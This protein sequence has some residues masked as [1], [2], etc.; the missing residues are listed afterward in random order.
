[1]NCTVAF[2]PVRKTIQIKASQERTFEI[3]AAGRWWP[4]QHTLLGAPRQ[5]LV[6]EPKAGGRWFERGTDGSECNWGKVLVWAPPERLVL[7]WEIN[8]H[9]QYDPS[10]TSEVEINFI[11]EG[12]QTTRVELEH[13]YFERFGDTADALRKGVD[14]PEG[15]TGV[16]RALAQAA[17]HS[18]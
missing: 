18:A 8:G 7:G 5:A 1:M 11:A 2:A 6:I 4:K 10:A 15:W 3:F 17:E 13:R 14:T 12:P 16:L 9:F